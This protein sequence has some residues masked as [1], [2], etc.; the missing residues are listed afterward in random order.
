MFVQ[1]Q[2]NFMCLHWIVSF[3]H[4]VPEQLPRCTRRRALSDY[5]FHYDYFPADQLTQ[6]HNF[7]IIIAQHGDAALVARWPLVAMRIQVLHFSALHKN[8]LT[9]RLAAPLSVILTYAALF[10]S[11]LQNV[12]DLL[13]GR[14]WRKAMKKR[15]L[16]VNNESIAGK[17]DREWRNGENDWIMSFAEVCSNGNAVHSTWLGSFNVVKRN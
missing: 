12:A 17:S 15:N 7:S 3:A 13:C 5:S 9:S 4:T 16:I 14:E 2:Q 10:A 8:A 11:L 1:F 6:I